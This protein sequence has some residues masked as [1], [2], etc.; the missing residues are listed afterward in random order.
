MNDDNLTK[1]ISDIISEFVRMRYLEVIDVDQAINIFEKSY[2]LA[3][4]L[5]EDKKLAIKVVIK[6]MGKFDDSFRYEVRK[7][8]NHK[9]YGFLKTSK[10]IPN[11]LQILQ[12]LIYREANFYEINKEKMHKESL[13]DRLL[14]KHY[15]KYLIYIC[16]TRN[17]FY[18]LVGLCRLLFNYNS[19]QTE[20]ISDRLDVVKESS[21]QRRCKLKLINELSERFGSLLVISSEIHNQKGFELKK[22]SPQE[23]VLVK[24]CLEKFTPW[25]FSCP[26]D[27]NKENPLSVIDT[28]SFLY[29]KHKLQSHYEQNIIHLIIHPKCFN[30]LSEFW[31]NKSPWENLEIPKFNITAENDNDLT[32][33]DELLDELLMAFQNFI[34]HYPGRLLR[35]KNKSE[36]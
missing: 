8:S 20:H 21:Q 13:N 33:K 3:Y 36:V 15:I 24:E 2:D 4:F 29:A 16:V 35:K 7:R 9:S 31:L 23:K 28:Y 19:N 30:V 1:K 5:L 18:V 34:F 27:E 6:A 10:Y 14:I 22:A 26:L 11:E 25:G 12:N 32:Y 17:T